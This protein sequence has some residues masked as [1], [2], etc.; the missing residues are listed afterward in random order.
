[1]R[2]SAIK[3]Q[4]ILRCQQFSHTACG[5]PVKQQFYTVGYLTPQITTYGIGENIAG[6]HLLSLEFHKISCSRG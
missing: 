6:G 3:A 1:M 2:A 5:N 4:A